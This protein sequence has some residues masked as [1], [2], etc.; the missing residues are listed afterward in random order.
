MEMNS[1]LNVLFL[2]DKNCARSQMAEAFV[3]K[4]AGDRFNVLSAGLHPEPEIHPLV[5]KVMKEIGIS[6]EGQ[7]AKS[8]KEYLA[9]IPPHYLIVAMNEE[10]RPRI[11]PGMQTRLHW[12]FEDPRK[13]D[14]PEEQK[15]EAFRRVRDQIQEKVLSWLEEMPAEDDSKRRHVAMR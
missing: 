2:C 5:F 13:A 4:Y 10:D 9:K 8:V 11:F 6:L 12:P 14:G 3:R 1:R 7:Q 15:I